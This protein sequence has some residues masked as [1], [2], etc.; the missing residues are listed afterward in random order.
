MTI[1]EAMQEAINM[2]KG[3]GQRVFLTQDKRG[4]WVWSKLYDSAWLFQVYP[5]GRKILSMEGEKLVQA[6]QSAQQGVAIKCG[7]AIPVQR[8]VPAVSDL[9]QPVWAGPASCELYR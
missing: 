8:L 5:G 1:F 7:L 3:S 6:A 2:A 4:R 9:V